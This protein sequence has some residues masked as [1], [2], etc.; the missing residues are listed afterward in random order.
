MLS[1]KVQKGFAQKDMGVPTN[2]AATKS[3]KDPALA[4]L[5]NVRDEAPYV[6]LYLDT[7]FGEN[8][9]GAMNDSIAL[10]FAGKAGPEDI[11]KTTQAAA[12]SE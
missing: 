4:E 2:P 6:Q 3:L 12:E 9:G 7:L 5:V 1:D 8:V 10:M 11:V